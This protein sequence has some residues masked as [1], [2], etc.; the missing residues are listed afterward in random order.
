M[1]RVS[2]DFCAKEV[3]TLLRQVLLAAQLCAFCA[4]FLDL[5]LQ[6]QN[7]FWHGISPFFDLDQSALDGSGQLAEIS[8][9]LAGGLVGKI[10]CTRK[11]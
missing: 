11:L 10:P 5:L 7:V 6:C 9:L 8:N 2:P 1:I 3:T 4:D